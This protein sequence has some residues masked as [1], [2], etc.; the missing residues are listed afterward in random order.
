VL[1]GQARIP[2]TRHSRAITIYCRAAPCPACVRLAVHCRRERGGGGH[3][4]YALNRPRFVRH[5]AL[6]APASPSVRKSRLAAHP[7]CAPRKV[8]GSPWLG[9][10][11]PTDTV[12]IRIAS[13]KWD[14]ARDPEWSNWSQKSSNENGRKSHRISDPGPERGAQAA[15]GANSPRWQPRHRTSPEKTVRKGGATPA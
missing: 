2:P 8:R 6:T 9:V 7:R 15:V 5:A 13:P 11:R 4:S 10:I 3:E 12:V 14:R 1:L